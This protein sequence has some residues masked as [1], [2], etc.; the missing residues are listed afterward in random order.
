MTRREAIKNSALALSIMALPV[1][2]SIFKKFNPLKEN[3]KF[4]AIIIGGSYAGLSA[5][6]ALGRSLRNVLIIDSGS[7]C[8]QSTPYSH[9]LIT[10]DGEKPNDI[11]QKAKEQVLKYKTVKFLEGLAVSGNK[12]D[13]GFEITTQSGGKLQ[14]KNLIFA[15]GV[16]DIMPNIDGFAECWGKT[17]I[18]CP[19]CHGFEVKNQ[20][21]GILANGDIA[22]HY[23]Q[24]IINWTKKLNIFTNGKASFTAEQLAKIK[25]NKI[26]IIEKEINSFKH[27]N[28]S[29][30]YIS[31]ND[32]TTYPVQAIYSRPNNEQHC[33][34]PEKLGCEINE[35][36]LIK[37]DMFQKT[38]VNGVFACGD[39]SSPY[40]AVS[41][42]ISAGNIA[43]TMLNNSMTEEEF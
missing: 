22:Y 2:F 39:N 26:S 15:T 27:E 41:Y 6:M 18:H 42:A 37:V 24:L 19:Y 17:I 43:A 34:I 7:P 1:P 11:T 35:Q 36:G 20:E 3:K 16:K 10:Q 33:P 8:N 12:I 4:D 38:T 9:N 21:T 40:R 29:I 25:A 23:A 32:N 5:G 28:G 31:F 14:A 30:K 13:G